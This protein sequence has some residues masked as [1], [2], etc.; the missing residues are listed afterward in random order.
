[1]HSNFITPPD[2]IETVLVIDA[3]EEDIKSLAECI[4]VVGKSYNVYFYNSEMNNFDWLTKVID[5]SDIV[6]MHQESQ[7]P[8]LNKVKFGP[9]EIFKQPMDY[10][11]K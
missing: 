2:L 5:R 6:L 11:N 8:V 10:F 4:K 3:S 9:D 7:V 1:M